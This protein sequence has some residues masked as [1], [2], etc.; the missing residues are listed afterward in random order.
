M[1]DKVLADAIQ[2]LKRIQTFDTKQLPRAEKLGELNFA[3]A[4]PPA[5]RLIKLFRQIP[6]D[7]LSEL[8]EQQLQTILDQ[9]NAL[10]N[11]FSQIQEFNLTQADPTAVRNSFI[12]QLKD[13]YPNF[14]AQLHPIISY[15]ATRQHDFSAMALDFKAKLQAAQDAADEQIG[16]LAGVGEE[17]QRVLEEVRKTAAEQGVSQKAFYFQQESERHDREADKWQRWSVITAVG[18]GIYAILSAFIHKWPWLAPA[19]TYQAFQLGIS[20]VLIFAVLAYMLILCVRNFLSHKHNAI[21]NRHRQNALLTF[22][23]L[24]DAAGSEER[25]DVILTYAASCIFAPQDTGYTKA[26]GGSQSELPLNIIQAIPKF[27]SHAQT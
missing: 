3:E 17:A 11:M 19:D 26:A 13:T 4:V 18:V 24:V 12:Q 21:V 7:F 9:S 23:A 15:C 5:E 8:P 1:A 20:K 14:F 2:S 6:T 22:N 10:Y 27:A 16:K 25:R